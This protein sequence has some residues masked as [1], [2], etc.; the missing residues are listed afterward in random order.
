MPHFSTKDDPTK[1]RCPH[2]IN[3]VIPLPV[4]RLQ[5]L[6]KSATAHVDFEPAYLAL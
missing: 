1:V 4:T 3:L 2:T 6:H 5:V